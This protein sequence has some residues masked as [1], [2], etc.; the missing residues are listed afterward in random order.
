MIFVASKKMV[1]I[2]AQ[3]TVKSR[4]V[5]RKCV[6]T[7]WLESING[8]FLMPINVFSIIADFDAKTN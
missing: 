2:F 5:S 1:A 7:I 3:F 4:F 8:T 6:K